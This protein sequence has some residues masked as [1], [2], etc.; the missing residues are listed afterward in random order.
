MEI[1]RCYIGNKL[2]TRN[3]KNSNVK[4]MDPK[5]KVREIPQLKWADD[6]KKIAGIN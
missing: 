5:L 3:K 1:L 2:I 6:I 4:K